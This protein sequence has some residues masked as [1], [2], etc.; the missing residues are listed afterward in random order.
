[1]GGKHVGRR[2]GAYAVET[3]AELLECGLD[4]GGREGSRGSIH[5]GVFVIDCDQVQDWLHIAPLPALVSAIRTHV[6][7]RA[8]EKGGW[9]I[10][11]RLGCDVVRAEAAPSRVAE[12]P[13]P[14]VYTVY[15]RYNG[16]AIFL[17]IRPV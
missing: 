12:P 8:G 15:P 13:P 14:E 17:Q 7:G 11:T 4:V 6:I 5:H 9:T 3:A 2:G 10:C 16:R 1:M